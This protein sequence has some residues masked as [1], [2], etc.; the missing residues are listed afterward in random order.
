MHSEPED[1]KLD[2]LEFEWD[3][4]SDQWVAND[5]NITLNL[6]PDFFAKGKNLSPRLRWLRHHG[7]TTRQIEGYWMAYQHEDNK[8][9]AID[10]INNGTGEYLRDTEEEA[11][12]DLM[13]RAGI[14][15][16]NPDEWRTAS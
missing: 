2:S 13:E 15:P 6:E 7:I 16:F 12:A 1:K 14:P 3:E 10:L 5:A 4:S 9:P 8:I 11:I